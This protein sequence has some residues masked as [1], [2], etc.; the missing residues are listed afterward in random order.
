MAETDT[1]NRRQGSRTKKRSR[2]GAHHPCPHC[3]KK[4]RTQKAVA[5][6]ITDIHPE[7]S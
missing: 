5:Q 7:Q 2:S 3:G 4:V 1:P 6:H